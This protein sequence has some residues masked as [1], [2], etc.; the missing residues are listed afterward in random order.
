LSLRME[1]REGVVLGVRFPNKEF[2]KDRVR[3]I[4]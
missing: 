2:V 3:R 1:M 4:L